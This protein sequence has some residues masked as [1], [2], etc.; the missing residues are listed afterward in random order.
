MWRERMRRYD[1][2]AKLIRYIMPPPGIEG[3][4]WCPVC[5]VSP[6]PTSV[7]NDERHDSCGTYIGDSCPSPVWD[8][9]RGLLNELEVKD[10][11]P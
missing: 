6:H 5:K 9:I 1:R 4:W 8:E 7:T 10:D 11:K 3:E 2:L